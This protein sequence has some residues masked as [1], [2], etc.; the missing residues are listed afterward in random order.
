MCV[1]GVD[2]CVLGVDVVCILVL[3]CCILLDTLHTRTHDTHTLDTHSIHTPPPHLHYTHSGFI[4]IFSNMAWQG[5]PLLISLVSLG[6]YTLMGYP[7]T[8]AIAFPALALFNQL[9]CVCVWGGGGLCVCWVCKGG[10]KAL[11]NRLRWVLVCVGGV[12]R[13]CR[14]C[15]C[16]CVCWVC[17]C[18]LVCI[19]VF[20][21]ACILDYHTYALSQICSSSHVCIIT[22]THP[23]T[24]THP[25]THSPRTP[26]H[27]H[28]VSSGSVSRTN[29]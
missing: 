1:L 27:H 18:V 29:K 23:H 12:C 11:F 9:R 4:N 2:V 10:C 28:Q 3:G 6:T 26:T 14:W 20:I 7:L 5:G 25:H 17:V 22:R 13:V 21:H 19:G 24:Y 15:V 16:M 8:A